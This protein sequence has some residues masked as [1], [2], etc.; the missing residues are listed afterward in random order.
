MIVGDDEGYERVDF[1]KAWLLVHL[2]IY[3]KFWLA[4]L[5]FC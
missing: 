5:F 3:P 4:S 1:D 2:A